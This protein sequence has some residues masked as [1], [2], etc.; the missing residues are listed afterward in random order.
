MLSK[1]IKTLI[2]FILIGI[3]MMYAQEIHVSGNASLDDPVQKNKFRQKDEISHLY[4]KT[5]AIGWGFLTANLAG[6]I[7]LGKHCSFVFPVYYSACN[8]FTSKVK[9]RTTTLQPEIRYWFSDSHSGWFV[10]A[11]MGISWFNVAW[12]SDYR[13][14][15]HD[16]CTPAIGGGMAGG[17]RM[18]LNKNNRWWLEFSLGAGIYNVNYDKF[19]NVPDGQWLAN[20][21]KISFAVDQVAV[22]FVYRF[23]LKKKEAK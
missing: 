3:Q 9:F 12:G 8:Y 16:R 19:Q 11:H 23:D 22:S 15:D 18:P 13:Y 21:E 7:D 10:G 6:E 20:E 14:Q 5:N 17:Y 4:I 2:V 1:V